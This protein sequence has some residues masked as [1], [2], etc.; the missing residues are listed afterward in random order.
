M[1]CFLSFST[2]PVSV[3]ITRAIDYRFVGQGLKINYEHCQGS[4]IRTFRTDISLN[5]MEFLECLF[6][7]EAAVG[8]SQRGIQY[9]EVS[10]SLFFLC[11]FNAASPVQIKSH[12]S[13]Q[14]SHPVTFQLLT[15]E[16]PA[17]EDS[18]VSTCLH[19]LYKLAERRGPQVTTF[20]S[21][22]KHISMIPFLHGSRSS[23]LLFRQVKCVSAQYRGK[24]RSWWSW[25]LFAP[26]WTS[27]SW[28]V[29]TLCCSL[30]N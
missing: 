30:K 28:T 21:Q 29:S 24:P 23:R 5:Q 9:T 1:K 7:S 3:K 25:A 19:L 13:F 18:S 8:G 17:S 12:F 10:V 20:E 2:K 16:T 15:F 4:N 14:N 22:K 11:C 6:P 27:A 26:N